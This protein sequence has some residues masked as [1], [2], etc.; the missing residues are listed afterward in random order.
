MEYNLNLT[1]FW[2]EEQKLGEKKLQEHCIDGREPWMGW[3]W[4]GGCRAVGQ[5][6][7]FRTATLATD[8][9]GCMRKERLGRD[10]ECDPLQPKME[11]LYP[12]SKNKTRSQLT[13]IMNS[14]L[15]NLDIN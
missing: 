7:I 11:K 13:Q 4:G 3:G 5:I 8:W 12:V 9:M 2:L 14:L 1:K 10:H 15:P 6:C